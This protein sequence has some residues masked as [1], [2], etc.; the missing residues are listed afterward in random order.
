M[1]NEKI[2]MSLA[3]KRHLRVWRMQAR[4]RPKRLIAGLGYTAV[5]AL[6]PYITVWFSARFVAELS[7]ARDPR[8][9]I[10]AA[11]WA[12]ISTAVT[13]LA[14]ALLEHWKK[15]EEALDTDFE[16]Q[17]YMNK[18]MSM[19]F[20]D[21]DGQRAQSLYAQVDQVRQMS[22]RG[23]YEATR[24]MQDIASGV[25][26]V[27]GGVALSVQLFLTPVPQGPMTILNSP[28]FMA[29][30]LALMLGAA[31]LSAFLSGQVGK[32]WASY[33]KKGTLGNRIFSFYGYVVGDPK[34]ALDMRI[35]D[36]QRNVCAPNWNDERYDHFGPKSSIARATRGATG[37]YGGAG[38]GVAALMTGLVYLFVCLK[39][40]GGAF[41]LGAVTQYI[42]VST[43]LFIGIADLLQ[44]LATLRVSVAFLEPVFE[45]LDTPNNMYQGS[46]T[47]EKRSDRQYEVE[48]RDVSF[49]YPGSE[50]YALRHVS[51]KFRVGSRL[52]V[53]GMNGSGKTTFIKLLCR[54]YD[55]DEGQILLNGIDIRKYRYDEYMNIF[56]V[57]FQDFKLLSLPLGQNVAA[58]VHYD[59]QRV[60]ECL[61]LAG[62][63]ERLQKMP[64]GLDTCLYK[65]LEQDGVEI[66]GG[67]AQKIAI[68]RALYK[69]A[70]FIIL[71]EPT[72]A[73]DPIAEAEIYEKFNEIAGDKT[74]VYISHRLSSCKFCD[75]IAVF[76][77]GQVVQTGTHEALLADTQG[78]YYEL[79]HAQAQYYAQSET[80]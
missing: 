57:V 54:L 66:S 5:C 75:E 34:R 10:G 52:A 16:Q 55:P 21:A 61:K 3:W 17:I 46:L 49:R 11:V 45:L 71:D 24:L 63:E 72:A 59:A 2:K 15:A 69:D 20:V 31:Q 70:P 43:A 1:A 7:G 60:R 38:R 47:T 68:A 14:R 58:G 67:E 37:L 29:A 27:L 30:M 65:D 18:F 44:T 12:L 13:M 50:Q 32:Y 39:A 36:Q 76:D 26:S 9:L 19:D 64:K 22:G 77:Q 51:M 41:G 56:S 78:K 4:M 35:Y 62:F 80:A 33:S 8:R 25:F 79:W 42:G 53:V 28:V 73:L 6:T 74:A 23:L 40:W 48:L